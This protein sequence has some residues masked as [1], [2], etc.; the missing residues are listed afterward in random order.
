MAWGAGASPFRGRAART[1][2][3]RRR[4]W[5]KWVT[6]IRDQSTRTRV[7]LG[8]YDSAESAARVYDMAARLLRGRPR[9]STSP[10]TAP[11]HHDPRVT[12]DALPAGAP[13]AHGQVQGRRRPRLP[14]GKLQGLSSLGSE[15]VSLQAASGKVQ[16]VECP[17]V[18]V[19]AGA[20]VHGDAGRRWCL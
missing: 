12:A 13:Q 9:A 14:H 17:S 1:R 19:V 20:V 18:S 8:S 16:I 10:R 6:E 7:W 15:M 2:G 4:K 5:G 11:P 3:V